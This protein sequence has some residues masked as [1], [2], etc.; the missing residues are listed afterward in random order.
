MSFSIKR[1]A[2]VATSTIF[3]FGLIL[4]VALKNPDFEGRAQRKDF[5]FVPIEKNLKDHV[6]FLAH[7]LAPRNSA[8]L[9]SLNKAA[10]YIFN[11]FAS[12]GVKPEFQHFTADGLEYKNVRLRLKGKSE[13]LIVIGAHYDVN[14]LTPGADDNASGVAGLL[15]LA[16]FLAPRAAELPYSLELVAY[17][18]EEPPYFGTE[19]MGSFIHARELVESKQTVELMISLEMIGF[20]S[21]EP[22]SQKYPSPLLKLFYPNKGDF[23]ALV[24]NL[25]ERKLI[26]KLRALFKQA[27]SLPIQSINAPSALPGIDFSDHRNYWKFEIPAVMLTDTAFFRNQNYHELSDRADSLDYVR[28]QEVVRAVR[29]IAMNF[30]TSQK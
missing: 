6:N 25:S 26:R 24:G 15:E 17:S 3:L 2:I 13:N 23:I 28:M 1:L 9:D 11:Y 18:L 21:D 4:F 5:E 27:S 10:D 22:G 8:N 19:S 30:S 29:Y 7:G 14:G 16:R 12:T 20:F